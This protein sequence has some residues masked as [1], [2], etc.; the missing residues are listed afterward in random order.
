MNGAQIV[1]H[2]QPGGIERLVLNLLRFTSSHFN[3]KVIALEGSYKQ[4]LQHWPELRQFQDKLIF[5]NKP[6]GF[7][8]YIFFQLR[9]I[10]KQH[11]IQFIHSHHLG[12]LFYS[13]PISRFMG[14]QHVHTEH[15]S[16]HLENPKA[17]KQT[18]LL[19]TGKHFSLIADANHI[20]K[21]LHRYLNRDVDSVILNGIDSKIFTLGD[22]VSAR[23]QLQ[24]PSDCF[25]LGAAGRLVAEK[26]MGLLLQALAQ[27]P[28][29]YHVAIAGIGPQQV[30]LKQQAKELGIQHRVH[31][32]NLV[33]DM[34]IF[35]QAIDLFCLPSVNE[36]LPLSLLEA[37]SCG[38]WVI[39]TDVGAVR[40]VITSDSG[41]IIADHSVNKLV[42]AILNA[43][44][45]PPAAMIRKHIIKNTDVRIMVEQYE[46]IWSSAL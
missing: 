7:K 40:E 8:P 9:R 22:P 24:L 46:K 38:K 11:Q 35:Y 16:W 36:G 20:A 1:Q 39:A 44:H 31:W 25:L 15:D 33:D 28:L 45:Q 13:R 26:G 37:Q 14:L 4:A 23:A 2:L 18:Q 43:P 32:L 42:N 6:T 29:H 30:I 3:L 41:H 17:R 27:L 5:L 12:P 19:A 21:D 34:P 10:V